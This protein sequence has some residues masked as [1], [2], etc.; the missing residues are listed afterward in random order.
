M[1]IEC[2]TFAQNIKRVYYCIRRENEY[3]FII[4][5]RTRLYYTYQIIYKTSL[6]EYYN[7]ES[8]KILTKFR[9]SSYN[10][11]FISIFSDL[12][13]L[14][15]LGFDETSYKQTYCRGGGKHLSETFLPFRRQTIIKSEMFDADGLILKAYFFWFFNN[16]RFV[17]R[18]G[19]R[20]GWRDYRFSTLIIILRPDNGLYIYWK[21]TYVNRPTI[22]RT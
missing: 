17:N 15:L 8:R 7:N 3:T 18:A 19:S 10:I 21:S 5:I 4:F 14:R 20:L 11:K 1:S 6:Y 16:R 22:P 12:L 13:I 2:W 9:A